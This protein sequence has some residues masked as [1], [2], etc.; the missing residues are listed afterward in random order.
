MSTKEELLFSKQKSIVSTNGEPIDS[1]RAD[2]LN[3]VSES[4]Y[5]D[6]V[7]EIVI[8]Q[9]IQFIYIKHIYNKKLE[10]CNDNLNK[11]LDDLKREI[12]DSLN[13]KFDDNNNKMINKNFDR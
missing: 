5:L 9:V 11:K 13:K 6:T 4:G 2:E 1:N 8:K 7:N 3:N 12:N 10:E